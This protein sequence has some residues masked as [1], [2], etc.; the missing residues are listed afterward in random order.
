MILLI[1]QYL[2]PGNYRSFKVIQGNAIALAHSDEPY[3]QKY[4]K[5]MK[6]HSTNYNMSR[7]CRSSKPIPTPLTGEATKP[8]RNAKKKGKEKEAGRECF[9][10][11]AE[12]QS[13]TT[14]SARGGEAKLYH[15]KREDKK[16]HSSV[17]QSE[18]PK[19]PDRLRIQAGGYRQDETEKNT[20]YRQNCATIEW[21]DYPDHNPALSGGGVV[22]T[23]FAGTT[24]NS[25][26]RLR[27]RVLCRNRAA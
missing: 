1:S 11:K 13:S 5:I 6:L 19:Y 3:M 14:T 20:E 12:N 26:Q 23:N 2:H 27:K 17:P 9:D 24:P 10:G 25:I 16:S 22:R 15:R 7:R 8:T 18:E 4:G 21:L